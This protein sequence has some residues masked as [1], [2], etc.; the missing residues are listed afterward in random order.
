MDWLNGTEGFQAQ[1]LDIAALPRVELTELER[2]ELRAAN[3][4]WMTPPRR[5]H[6]SASVQHGRSAEPLPAKGVRSSPGTSV[7][8]GRRR[9]HQEVARSRKR[10]FHSSRRHVTIGNRNATVRGNRTAGMRVDERANEAIVPAGSLASRRDMESVAV[11]QLHRM[12]DDDPVED[13][14][15]NTDIANAPTNGWNLKNPETI[16]AMMKKRKRIAKMRKRRLHKKLMSDPQKRIEVFR[17]RNNLVSLLRNGF[18]CAFICCGLRRMQT[19]PS[20]RLCRRML[21]RSRSARLDKKNRFGVSLLV[22]VCQT[23]S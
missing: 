20:R 22:S 18:L 14:R 3:A 6:D 17:K 5:T 11:G 8:L 7:T 2:S 16:A 15:E 13:N 10:G 4:A 23:S 19:R 1:G 9:R 21:D 12:T